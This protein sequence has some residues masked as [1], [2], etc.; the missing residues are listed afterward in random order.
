VR[1][2]QLAAVTAALL[3]AA[4]VA[5]EA[6]VD[7]IRAGLQKI[8]PGVEADAIRPAPLD[9][10]YEVVIG[11]QLVYVSGDGRYLFQGSIID[12]QS[13]TDLTEPRRRAAVAEAVEAVGEDRMVV[14]G[15][16]DA[17]HTVT[18]FTDIDCGYCRKLH[19]EMDA[20][21]DK[22]I[23]VR[24]LFFPRAG[25]NSESFDKAVSVWCAD[26]SRAAMT[27]AK[28]GKPVPARTCDNPVKEHMRL[29]EMTGVTGTPALVLPDGELLPGYVPASRLSAYLD[30]KKAGP[31]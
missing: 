25:V 13:R 22:G 17:E 4:L 31:H 16:A 10:L 21:N 6:A 8:L 26:D 20:F 14:F 30:G 9:N 5:E 2:L 7:E 29:G 23:R 1:W 15:D 28:A 27:D 3:P 18:V 24:Y 12:M 19:A 11:P